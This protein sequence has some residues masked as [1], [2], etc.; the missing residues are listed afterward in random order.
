MNVFF[1]DIEEDE[2]LS[3]D[4]PIDWYY[5]DIDETGYPTKCVISFF[6][7]YLRKY[8]ISIEIWGV[9][10][11][12]DK[13]MIKSNDLDLKILDY[14]DKSGYVHMKL[15]VAHGIIQDCQCQIEFHRD[16]YF[17]CFNTKEDGTIEEL[18]Y[19]DDFCLK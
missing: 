6:S 8:N 2:S 16:F 18:D 15:N 14:D 9:S 11:D 3:M 4:D 17:F 19:F 10:F 13:P 1:D 12:D 5:D 7:E